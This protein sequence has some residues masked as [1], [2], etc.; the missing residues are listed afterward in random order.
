MMMEQKNTRQRA[1]KGKL[2]IGAI[3]RLETGLHIGASS[4]FAPIGAVDSPFLRDPMTKQPIIPGSSLKGK[5]RTLLARSFST[6]EYFLN[7]I[8]EDSPVIQ[9][10]FGSA[11][12]SGAGGLGAR[13]QFSDIRM[14]PESLAQF[15][16]MELDT[17]IGEIKFENSIN[18]ATAV[19][20]PRQIER[21]P[22]GT[23]FAF[24]L[25]YNI[26]RPAE[27]M[28]DMQILGKGLRLLQM[29]YLGGHGSRGYGRVL[30]RDFHVKH[31]TIHAENAM[32]QER[33]QGIAELLQKGGGSM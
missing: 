13:L 27:L 4:D 5:I 15:G 9:R 29:D 23:E 26:E 3:L 31:F 17:Y 6:D 21:L 22:A 25:V 20:N 14:T 8:D 19:A 10:L 2:D 33:L 30:L 18:R 28:E 7:K 32:P 12:Q 1:L 16:S 24:T 11:A